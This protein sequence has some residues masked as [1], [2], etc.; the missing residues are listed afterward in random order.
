MNS[1]EA[2]GFI[3][4]ALRGEDYDYTQGSIKKAVFLLAIPMMLEMCLES[5]FSVVDIFFVNK[6][7]SHAVSAVG[8]TEAVIS[9]VYSIAIG[10]SAAATAIVSRRVG[11]KN[12]EGASKAAIQSLLVSFVI[13]III[14]VLGY[15][16]AKEILI[17]MGAEKEA[18][19]IGVEYTQIMLGSSAVIVLLFLMN[20]IFRG[21]GNASIAMKSL[22]IG[23]GC[24]II[25]SP[26]LISG[27]GPFPE[28]GVKGAAIATVLGRGV[29]V[30]YQLYALFY[31]T[32]QHLNLKGISWIPDFKIIQNLLNIAGPATFQFIIQSASWIFLA[33]L[34]ALS[35]SDASAGYQ[36]AL[37][38]IIFFILP[39]W[40]ISNAAATLVGQNLGANKPDRASLSVVKIAK[41]N[42]VFMG[43]VMVFFLLFA[44]VLISIFIPKT[45]VAQFNYATDALKIIGTGYVLYGISMVLMQAFNGAGD[46]K[47]PTIVNIIGFWLLQIPFAYILGIIFKLGPIGVYIAI[48]LCEG[49]IAFIY[50]YLFKKGNWKKVHV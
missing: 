9:L 1:R 19:T 38:L 36:T 18:V 22:W 46:T 11:E 30:L 27:Y 49:I 32:N 26:L 50:L 25:L 13:I 43:V 5:V 10:L 44:D 3:K 6:L 12:T 4:K 21:A 31:K 15:T 16:Y 8:L 42:A 35:G 40:G 34:I 7:G 17:L 24:N 47:T 48:P 45:S 28:L 29:G 33:A 39:S 23:N 41:Y 14:S 20:G 37:R 2:I